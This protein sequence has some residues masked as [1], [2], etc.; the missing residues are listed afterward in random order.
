MSDLYLANDKYNATLQAG[1]TVG[2]TTLYVSAVPTNVPTIVTINKG[3]SN[4]TTFTVTGKTSN[5]LTGVARLKGANVNLDNSSPVTIVNNSEFINQFQSTGVEAWASAT[6]GATITF[7]LTASKKQRVTIAGNRTLAVNGDTP[8]MAFITRIKQD[9]T[10][11]R[12]VTWWSGISWA[13]GSAPTL[14]TTANKADTFGF[15]QTGT[16][17]YDGFVVGQNI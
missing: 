5:S 17:T 15:I 3:E 2:D 8:G 4:E 13:D 9:A 6:D 14:T 7:D 16:N 1:Y 10:G 12:T 11:S